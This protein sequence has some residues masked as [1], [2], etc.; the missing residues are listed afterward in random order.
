MASHPNLPKE[1][2]IMIDWDSG[3]YI[4]MTYI[5]I[6]DPE[7]DDGSEVESFNEDDMFTLDNHDE[8]VAECLDSDDD[9]L[10]SFDDVTPYN[11][12]PGANAQISW[13][14]IIIEDRDSNSDVQSYL[15]DVSVT[16]QCSEDV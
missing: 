12:D 5:S 8:V 10:A 16:P 9:K 11:L 4:H 14:D 7:E 15:D 2:S 6:S 3:Q 13:E 1:Q